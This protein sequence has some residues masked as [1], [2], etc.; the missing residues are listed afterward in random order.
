VKNYSKGA[1]KGLNN[2]EGV[3]AV[4]RL[5]AKT[6][7]QVEEN[8]EADWADKKKFNKDNLAALKLMRQTIKKMHEGEGELGK[9]KEAVDAY[10]AA[11]DVNSTE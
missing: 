4:Q 10:M 9:D 8:A 7:V 6:I 5:M 3:A 11:P 1:E 2:P